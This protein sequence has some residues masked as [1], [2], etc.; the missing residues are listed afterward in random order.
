MEKLHMQPSEID[1]LPF[2]E[3]EYTV[4]IF[5]DILKERKDSELKN[6]GEANK[7]NTSSMKPNYKHPNIKMPNLKL[8]KI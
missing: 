2:Y 5:N 6:Q 7:Y 4:E 8:P 1:S 3:Y